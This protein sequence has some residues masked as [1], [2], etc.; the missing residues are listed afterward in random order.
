[1]D[2]TDPE[3]PVE[4]AYFDRGPVDAK[5]LANGGTWS[6]YWYNGRFTRRR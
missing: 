1:M 3:H 6:S 4:I 2:F 5:V